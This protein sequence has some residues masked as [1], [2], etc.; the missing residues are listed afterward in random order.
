METTTALKYWNT[1]TKLAAAVL[2]FITVSF[3][4]LWF[5]VLRPSRHMGFRATAAQQF[6][7][8]AGETRA[9]TPFS[10]RVQVAIESQQPL[11]LG[12]LPKEL[13]DTINNT[14]AFAPYQHE[15]KCA[16]TAVRDVAFE[17]QLPAG[18]W[19]LLIQDARTVKAAMPSLYGNPQAF[20]A[21]S[22]PNRVTLHVAEYGCL[23]CAQRASLQKDE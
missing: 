1:H 19:T 21:A 9:L 22:V 20:S 11:T 23:D 14:A 12:Y 18:T 10:G 5:V 7:L 3:L 17:C 13:A 2:G 6:A 15:M 16:R 4:L 8:N